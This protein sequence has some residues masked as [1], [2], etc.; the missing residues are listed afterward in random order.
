MVIV[1]LG[2]LGIDMHKL[3]ALLLHQFLE[4]QS[5]LA[6]PFSFRHGHVLGF[7]LASVDDLAKDLRDGGVDYLVL[8]ELHEHGP[9]QA[10]DSRLVLF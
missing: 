5:V 10:T 3:D 6:V 4:P 7:I 9:V 8:L 2:V 1:V